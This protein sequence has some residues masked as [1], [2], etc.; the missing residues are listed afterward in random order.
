MRVNYIILPGAIHVTVAYVEGS[1]NNRFCAKLHCPSKNISNAFD[2]LIGTIDGVPPN[3]SCTLM[4]TDDNA[5]TF[6]DTRAA[7]T[8]E[9]I[10]VTIATEMPTTTSPNHNTTMNQPTPNEG[11]LLLYC[12]VNYK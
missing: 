1:V 11:L 6:I 7:V 9:N 3:E 8:I 5:M 2:G 12:C 10:T 4:V